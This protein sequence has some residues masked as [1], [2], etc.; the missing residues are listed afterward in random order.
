MVLRAGVIGAG[1]MG[2]H[3]A[4]NLTRLPGVRLV[5]V[6]DTHPERAAA[7][8]G[9]LGARA[10]L[11]P[12]E[13]LGELDVVVIASPAGS[14]AG[15][16]R[17]ALEAGL[18]TLVE[19][20]LATS[21]SDAQSLATLARARGLTLQGGHLLRFHSQVQRL[22]A[23]PAPRQLRARRHGGRRVQDLGVALDL[24]IHDLDLALLLLGEEPGALWA[25]G[26]E[27]HLE[28]ELGFPSGA[29]AWLSA[30]RLA[31]PERTLELQ[32]PGGPEHLDYAHFPEENPLLASLAHF[33]ECA[34]GAS[35]RF[36]IEQDLRA[37]SLA[38]RARDALASTAD[39]SLQAE[40][41]AAQ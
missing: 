2:A 28:L 25:R 39:L 12:R 29:R 38:L 18:H 10:F 35:P 41:P 7:L 37:L 15:L 19:K 6:L 26:H 40:P 36:S 21:L 1:S 9:P 22:L 4:R 30:S 27:D 17:A 16:A 14:H 33:V 11:D 24:A 31:P 8:A 20:P 5:G 23:R 13:L 3:H 34:R 32:G